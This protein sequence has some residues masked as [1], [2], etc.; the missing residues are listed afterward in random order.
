[1]MNGDFTMAATTLYGLEN[2][3]AVEL[4]ELGA[5]NLNVRNR[6]VEFR[7]DQGFLYKANLM[8]RT[9]LR[10][11]VPISE[12]DIRGERD[13]YRSIKAVPWDQYFFT[14]Q[15]FSVKTVAHTRVLTSNSHYLSLKA[16]DAIVDFFRE[17]YGK[18][19]SIDTKNPDIRIQVYIQYKHCRVLLDSSGEAL[20]KRGYRRQTNQAPLNEVLGAGM[21]KIAG[22]DG[23]TDLLDPMCGSGTL[24]I[25]AAMMAARIPPGLS[26][27]FGFER[28]Q[29]FDE[30]LY[31]KIK[32]SQ[33]ARI[34]DPQHEITGYDIDAGTLRK[35]KMNIA[36]AHLEDF[37][38]LE[39]KD[40]FT[41]QYKE[42][43]PLLLVFN[44]PYGERL[45]VDAPIFYKKT[46]DT[47]KRNYQG[48]MAWIITPELKGMKH[49]GLH[50]CKKVKL[51]NGSLEC[52]FIQYELYEG[53]RK[54]NKYNE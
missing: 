13:Y 53:S 54:K 40:F 50:A 8:L 52:R 19:P 4:K 17:R 5:R 38:R 9:A 46:G 42:D 36:S 20:F 45:P 12:F 22:Y 1:M 21:L 7:G 35:A 10:V 47:L 6:A 48:A 34:R 27:D 49:T 18:R 23:S 51:Y 16:K 28:W 11:L 31:H 3:L 32:D 30:E 29:N 24:L 33:M 37:I 26:R 14:G 15:T 44:P 39:K 25:E 2:V 41:T 43:K